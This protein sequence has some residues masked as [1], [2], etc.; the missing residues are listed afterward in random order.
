MFIGIFG[1]QVVA[2]VCYT[3]SVD[4]YRL[5]GSEVSQFFNFCRQE[6][7]FTIGFYGLQLCKAIGYQYAFLMFALVGSLLAF[8]PVVVLIWRGQSIRERM[9]QPKNVSVAEEIAL[10]VEESRHS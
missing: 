1:I 7:S 10:Q 9:G 6:T 3:Y 5:E 4:C 8:A 2:T